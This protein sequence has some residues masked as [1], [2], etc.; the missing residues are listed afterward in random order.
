MRQLKVISIA[1]THETRTGL[2]GH[3]SGLEMVTLDGVFLEL[4]EAVLHCQS[5]KPDV[6]I[7]DFSGREVD[8]GLFIQN[9]KMNP[10]FGCALVALHRNPDQD[11]IL[12]AFRNGAQEFIHYPNDL[13]KMDMALRNQYHLINRTESQSTQAPKG[14]LITV[15]SAKGGGGSSTIALNL[16]YELKDATQKT[17]AVLDLDQVFTNSSLMLN[18]QPNYSLGDL[19]TTNPADIDGN[20]LNR[21]VATHDETGLRV[22]VGSKNVLDD[23]DLISP[24]LLEKTVDFLMAYF[25]YVVVDLPTHVLDPYHQYMIERSDLVLMVAALDIPNLSRTRQYMDLARRHLDM[26]RVKLVLNRWTQKAAYGMSND[27]VEQ[28][29]GYPVYAR[30]PNDWDLC[31]QASSLGTVFAQVKPDAEARKAIRTLAITVAGTSHAGHSEQNSPN[32]K[33]GL[34]HNLFKGLGKAGGVDHV[35]QQT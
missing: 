2:Q 9:I 8:A 1:S 18:L 19:T 16:A 15:F 29:F 30:I 10:E 3:L 31:V 17:V 5:H 25:D 24:E 14:Q 21:V 7:V 32:K 22:I 20:L 23:H 4:S 28:Q 26:S 13:D 27:S 12:N 11:I 35:V 6:I 34:I 33:A